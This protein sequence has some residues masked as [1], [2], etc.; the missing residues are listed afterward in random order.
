M[1]ETALIAFTTFFATIG[2]VDVA[3]MFAVLSAD[4][5]KKERRSAAYRATF[6]ASIILLIFALIGN[7]IINYLG[8]SIAALKTAGGILLLLVA[9]DMVFAIRSGGTSTTESET[10]EAQ[11]KND[12]AVFPVATP[13]I[14]GS[15]SMSAAILLT[16]GEGAEITNL[17]ITIAAMLSVVLLTLF[18]MLGAASLNRV[19]GITGMQAITRV[20]GV[21]L[22]ALAVQFI[23][24][25]L[26][27]SGLY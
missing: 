26:L 17:L 5:D 22:C 3:A 8:I 25:G 6:I 13:L 11:K 19:L 2:P 4:L 27:E 14:A 10:R 16:T 1:L 15:G 12:I 21:L 23:F 9:I 24:D 18:A 20:L 7:Q